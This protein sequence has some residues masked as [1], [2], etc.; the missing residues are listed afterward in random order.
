[1]NIQLNIQASS[2]TTELV[3]HG[4]LVSINGYELDLSLIPEGGEAEID[5][6]FPMAH[7]V[8]GKIKSD[9]IEIIYQYDSSKAENHHAATREDLYIENASGAIE[10]PIK[11]RSENV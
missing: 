2:E 1:M 3:V 8:R 11:W 5:D 9:F 4:S 7:L 10:P 6:S